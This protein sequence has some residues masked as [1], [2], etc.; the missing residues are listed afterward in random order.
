VIA[1]PIRPGATSVLLT[2]LLA[3]AATAAPA[4]DADCGLAQPAFCETFESGPAPLDDRG[5]GHELSRRRFSLTRYEPSLSTGNGQAFWVWEAELGQMD[6]EPEVCRDDLPPLLLPVIDTWVC[7]PSATIGSRYL[8]SAVGAQNYGSNAIRLRQPFDFAGRTGRI[9]FDADLADNFLLGYHSVVVSADPSPAPSWDLN[10][11]GPNPRTGVMLVFAGAG[12][13]VHQVEDYA[14][15][16]LAGDPGSVPAV[17]GRLV[18][19]EIRL[20]QQQV[21]V[22]T[23]EPSPDGLAFGPLVSRRTVVFPRPLEFTRGYVALLGHNHATWK[24]AMTF[25]NLPRPIRS[26]NTYWDNIGFDGPALDG[27]REYEIADAAVV[28]TESTTDPFPPGMQTT[29]VHTGMSLGYVIPN[30]SA[31]LSAPLTFRSVSLAHATRA[32]LVFNGY[33]QGYNEDGIRNG[34]GRLLYQINDA[35]LHVRAF[36]PGEVAMLDTPGQTGGYNHAIDLPLSE[37]HEGDN[38]VRFATA[39]IG[40]GYPNAVTNLDLLIDFDPQRVFADSFE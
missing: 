39:H 14:A 7:E 27:T 38:Q 9:A 29:I 12:V 10:G 33:Y 13:D 15:T 37:L 32:R 6:G 11:R 35:P 1:D 16:E 5:R 40:S 34:T 26:W 25:G 3:L 31:Q 4:G 23:S 30:D 8:L 19:V 28:S 21:E 17:R 24:Y 20:S 2:P 22:L 18:H 36:T